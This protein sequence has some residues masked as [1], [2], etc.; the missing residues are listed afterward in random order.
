MRAQHKLMKIVVT[1][2]TN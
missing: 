2:N 1:L